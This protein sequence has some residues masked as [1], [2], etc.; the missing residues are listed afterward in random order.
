MKKLLIRCKD[1]KSYMPYF[2][3]FI[4]KHNYILIPMLLAV[5]VVPAKEGSRKLLGLL[6]TQT[7]KS[8]QAHECNILD[9]Q[10]YAKIPLQS[11]LKQDEVNFIA[12]STFWLFGKLHSGKEVD[13][14]LL[15]KDKK[16]KLDTLKVD[17][18]RHFNGLISLPY[19]KQSYQLMLKSADEKIVYQVKKISDQKISNLKF[20]LCGNSLESSGLYETLSEPIV[21]SKSQLKLDLK[22]VSTDYLEVYWNS[23]LYGSTVLSEAKNHVLI[24]PPKSVLNTLSS[25]EVHKIT[26]LPKDIL[27]D[28][29]PEPQVIYYK[30]VE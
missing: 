18:K 30:I 14:F 20:D 27:Q 16:Y 2:I 23:I 9:S 12:D 25:N 19:F 21:C 6:T 8:C 1:L 22:G 24:A 11:N 4:K 13:V 5:L 3:K 28:F 26:L 29:M 10:F 7:I 17:E 15:D